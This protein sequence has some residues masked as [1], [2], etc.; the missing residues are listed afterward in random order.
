[1]KKLT[2]VLLS[3][4]MLMSV[5][6]MPTL[7]ASPAD[8][9]KANAAYNENTGI[10]ELVIRAAD[11]TTNGKFT[12]TFNDECLSYA[13]SELAGT[14]T[15]TVVD[16]DTI[17]MSYASS[18]E[19][20]VRANETVAVLRFLAKVQ[21]GFTVLE[22][23]V[24]E[25][26]SAENLHTALPAIVVS[27]ETSIPPVPPVTP[28]P[29]V[30]P[31]PPVDP[32]PPVE[33]PDDGKDDEQDKT[34]IEIGIEIPE[35][36]EE[37]YESIVA[38]YTDI[39]QNWATDSIVKAVNAG[40][41]NGTSDNTFSPEAKMTRAQLMT[42][43]ARLA[44][45]D[46]TVGATWYE[47]GME[48]S[49]ENG[50]SDGSNPSKNITRQELVTMLYRFAGEPATNGSLANFTDASSVSNY[51]VDA[52]KWAVENGIINGMGDGTLA[53]QGE[54]TRAQMAKILMFFIEL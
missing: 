23:M 25:C 51:A 10:V 5:L 8:T 4:V 42:V 24:L 14:L 49:K 44:G 26:N 37:K 47:K 18:T 38:Q 22:V 11:L 17:T 31:K 1:M 7:A 20:A 21:N 12:V 41:F 54:A 3:M 35:L 43:L 34:G 2:S 29:P 48:W 39:P 40:L 6:C 46:T 28:N 27:F 53:P 13:G 30:N 32:K 50:I 16:G 36:T 33:D 52:M 45:V 19:D 15:D 9:L